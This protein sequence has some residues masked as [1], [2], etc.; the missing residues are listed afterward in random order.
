MFK[1]LPLDPVVTMAKH[2]S[3]RSIVLSYPKCGRTWLLN[4][5]MNYWWRCDHQADNPLPF[6]LSTQSELARRFARSTGINFKHG[7]KLSAMRAGARPSIRATDLRA[8]KTTLLVRNPV[9]V[10]VSYY[11]HLRRPS[12]SV[13]F[14]GG[15]ADFALGPWGAEALARYYNDVMPPLL[16]NPRA[17][18]VRY[19][20]LHSASSGREEAFETLLSHHFGRIDVSALLWAIK[21]CEPDQLRSRSRETG[22]SRVRKAKIVPD[23]EVLTDDLAQRVHRIMHSSLQA[24]VF[25]AVYPNGSNYLLTSGDEGAAPSRYEDGARRA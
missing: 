1:A 11:H 7:G 2:L 13:K 21:S 8:L 14:D 16:R 6:V 12:K 9:S 23:D 5:F 25:S 3:G 10:I 17:Q 19:E 15:F 24:E 20:Q 18:V 4:V 22:P